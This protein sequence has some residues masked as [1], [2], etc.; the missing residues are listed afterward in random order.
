MAP[1]FDLP[2][3]YEDYLT[4]QVDKKQRHEIRRKQRRA[5]REA[6]IG[7]S[8]VDA[9]DCLE[10]EVDDFVALQ[11]ASRSDKADFMTSEMHRFFT[12]LARSMLDAGYLRL[13]FLTI[14]GEKAAS[15][16]AFEYDRQFLLYNS[17]YDPAAHAHLSPGWVF[18]A[19]QHPVCHRRRL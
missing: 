18:L 19:Y 14:D 4:H 9:S 8:I 11:R 3:H 12:G 1:S 10:A 7:F 13:F 15:L 5:E 2:A 17:G 6:D 16:Y